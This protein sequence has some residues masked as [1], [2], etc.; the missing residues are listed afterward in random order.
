MVSLVGGRLT[1]GLIIGISDTLDISSLLLRSEYD[2]NNKYLICFSRPLKG[3]AP[4]AC[5]FLGVY[6]IP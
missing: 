4:K 6:S 3:Q 2:S 5:H 1:V